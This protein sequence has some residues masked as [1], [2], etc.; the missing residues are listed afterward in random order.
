MCLQKNSLKHVLALFANACIYGLQSSDRP[1]CYGDDEPHEVDVDGGEPHRPEG[2]G[3]GG[4]C[5]DA[6]G[7]GW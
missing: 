4:G 1:R 7:G 2:K 5:G 6:D 3:G